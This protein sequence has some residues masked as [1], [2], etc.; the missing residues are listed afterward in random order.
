[1]FVHFAGQ[2]AVTIVIGTAVRKRRP[3]AWSLLFF[4]SV[5]SLVLQVLSGI[6]GYILPVAAAA[7]R[8]GV[9]R[10]Y[11]LMIARTLGQVPFT[12]ILFALLSIALVRLATP[13]KEPIGTLPG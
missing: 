2:V 12:I 3:D 6:V 11:E 13:P 4:W 1:M 5:F 7:S 8:G 9:E 10:H